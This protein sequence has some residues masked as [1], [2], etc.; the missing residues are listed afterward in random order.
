MTYVTY[1]FVPLPAV[2]VT[3]A[4]VMLKVPATYVTV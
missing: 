3:D 1:T 4:Y 2:S